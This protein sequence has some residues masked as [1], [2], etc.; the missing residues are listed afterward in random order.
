MYPLS[1]GLAWKSV[2]RIHLAK[3]SGLNEFWPA[4]LSGLLHPQVQGDPLREPQ[5]RHFLL[6]CLASGMLALVILPL[7]LALAGPPPLLLTLILAWMLGQLPLA[8]YLSNTGK[9]VHAHA[10]SACLFTVFLTGLGLMTGGVSS[11]AVIWLAAVPMQ[12]A[13]SG[14]GKVILIA[15]GLVAC[16]VLTWVLAAPAVPS[17][18]L[19][20][21][22][23]AAFAIGAACFYLALLA[24]HLAL[25]Q[26][27]C[28]LALAESQAKLHAVA[29]ICEDVML[30]ISADGTA[31]VAAGSLDRLLGL[32]GRQPRGDWLFHRLHVSDRPLYLCQLAS[33][34]G[35]MACEPF[36]V[37]LR[38]GE[39][40]PG[41]E[42]RAEYIWV[43]LKFCRHGL[44]DR[45]FLSLRDVTGRRARDAAL[46]RARDAA[47]DASIAKTRFIA[48]ASHE[49]RTPLNAIIGF[50]DML[51]RSQEDR[52]P[53][54]RRR[55]YANLINQSG[56][57]LLQLVDRMLDTSRIETG[58]M[59]LS[60]ETVDLA[61][62]LEGCRAMVGPLAEERGVEL[63]FP[64]SKDVPRLPADAHAL[65][66]IILNL[67]I[68][69]IK[70]SHRG[71]CVE[72]S[73]CV[74]GA[75]VKISFKDS[76]I[77][78]PAQ[79]IGRLGQPFLRLERDG[80]AHPNTPGNGLGLSIVKGLAELHG[81]RL[82]LESREGKGTTACVYLP[83]G[84]LRGATRPVEAAGATRTQWARSA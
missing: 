44:E 24:W 2:V 65:K 60:I 15:A 37:R 59:E 16:A 3:I 71:G 1:F 75:F 53:L 72:V 45:L 84:A 18:N 69:A 30:T 70:F 35:G 54:Q 48:S 83:A 40:M 27:R 67:V 20:S 50:S 56:Q 47:E 76:G 33:A 36:D 23:A 52:L 51:S 38:K 61:G 46:E 26:K 66:Q 13:L 21:P 79:M 55:E 81:G 82:T 43:Q 77:G 68:N 6:G 14:S 34:R 22:G 8:L 62:C 19:Y 58:H 9:L 29:A 41:E 42:G 32:S 39:T 4:S 74:D 11:F 17:Q 25:N 78:I 12:A 28:R 10:L 5:H 63:L 49:L 64:S 73:V 80:E 7:Y 31:R 57:H